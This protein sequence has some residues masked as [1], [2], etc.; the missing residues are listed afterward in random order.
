MILTV[1]LG[2]IYLFD[3]IVDK[4]HASHTCNE[5]EGKIKLILCVFE[6]ESITRWQD[7]RFDSEKTS[8]RFDMNLKIT[9]YF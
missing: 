2:L 6:N 5:M 3:V 8:S 9:N 7:I 4:M 1:I